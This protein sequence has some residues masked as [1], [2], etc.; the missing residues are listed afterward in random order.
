MNAKWR[1]EESTNFRIL[2]IIKSL[3]NE[4]TIGRKQL[5]F[6]IEEE[7]GGEKFGYYLNTEVIEKRDEYGFYKL[8]E[9]DNNSFLFNLESNGSLEIP[10]IFEIIDTEYG[11]YKLW[12]KSDA[13]F[14]WLGNIWLMKENNKNEPYCCQDDKRFEYHGIENALCG[15]EPERPL[16]GGMI[17]T[18]KR[19]L[20][21][22]MK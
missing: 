15:K 5:A 14:I 10:M 13:Y 18:P 17:F 19:I 6:L 8:T 2:N 4:R 11:V 20:V 9:T 3:S 22:Q 16:F 7:G 1:S 12:D 21:I